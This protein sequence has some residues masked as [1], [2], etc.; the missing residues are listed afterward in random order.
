MNRWIVG[1]GLM[2]T[3]SLATPA[4]AHVVEITTIVP[5]ADAAD[6]TKLRA[7]VQAAVDDVVKDAVPFRPTLVVLTRAVVVGDRV[8]VRV[9]L[10]D[11]DGERTVREL[12]QPRPE[13]RDGEAAADLRL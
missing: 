7:A 1:A 12:T 4:N 8:Y 11:P 3:A 13:S 6:H 2:L 5:V 10:A 9:L